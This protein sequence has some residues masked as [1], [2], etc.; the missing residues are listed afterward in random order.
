M[1]IDPIRLRQ[2]CAKGLNAGQIAIRLGTSV[3]GVH[4]AAKRLGFVVVAGEPTERRGNSS[5][6]NV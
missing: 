5:A 1:T 2:L 3:S 6:R 4:Q